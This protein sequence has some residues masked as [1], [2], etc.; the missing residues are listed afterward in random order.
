MYIVTFIH[1]WI[2]LYPQASQNEYTQ[3]DESMS[4]ELHDQ[5]GLGWAAA[6]QEWY[7]RRPWQEN[8]V[9]IPKL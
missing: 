7:G 8:S 9:W 3:Q 4:C 6:I 1:P 5:T 2:I